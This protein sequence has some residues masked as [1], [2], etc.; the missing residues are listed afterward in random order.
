ME[1]DDD[2]ENKIPKRKEKKVGILQ[3]L[4]VDVGNVFSSVRL[5]CVIQAYDGYNRVVLGSRR[6][7][8]LYFRL[9]LVI[10]YFGYEALK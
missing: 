4:I 3:R 2:E 9:F 6:G 5:R 7:F 10:L 8:L 1:S